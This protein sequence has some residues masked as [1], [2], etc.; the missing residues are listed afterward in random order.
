[1]SPVNDH[2]LQTAFCFFFLSSQVTHGMESGLSQKKK[3]IL[4]LL[5]SAKQFKEML[6]VEKANNG[7]LIFIL[8]IKQT[9]HFN[10]KN[11]H[12]HTHFPTNG[13]QCQAPNISSFDFKKCIPM[14]TPL[15]LLSITSVNH[16]VYFIKI[17]FW[18]TESDCP[19]LVPFIKQSVSFLLT[20]K[21]A[22]SLLPS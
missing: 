20:T 3:K 1:M 4:M 10:I 6:I 8:I 14:I 13:P 18:K 9:T 12:T 5:T 2:L 15:T 7:V 22:T 19:L 21:S 17:L 11:S 16:F